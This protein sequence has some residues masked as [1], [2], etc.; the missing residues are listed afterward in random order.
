MSASD[1]SAVNALAARIHP[2]FPE[3]AAVFA[4]RLRLYPDGC[5]VF[6]RGNG[7]EAYVV[8][9]P[10]FQIGPPVL[11]SLLGELP[12]TPAVYYIHD[13]AL[14]PEVRG[15]GAAPEIVAWLAAHALAS[16]LYGMSLIAVN[17]SSG[18]WQRQGFQITHIPQFETKLN[19]YGKDAVYMTRSLEAAVWHPSSREISALYERHAAAF[20]RDRGNRLVERAWFE[21]FRRVMPEGAA[22]LDLGCGSGEPVARYLI[23]A[24]HRVTGI[25]SSLTL[26]DLCRSRFPDQTWIAGDMRR[27]SL[28]RRF[29]GIVAWNSFFHLTPDDQRGMF[30][31]FRDRAE[32]G[33]ALMFTSGPAAGEAIGSYQGEALYHA[34]LA[35]AEYDALLAAHGFS[36]VQHVV[37]DPECGGLTVWLA[38]MR[39]A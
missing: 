15:L 12:A 27:V 24:G 1:L 10:W 34:S 14:A 8:S 9:H 26:I 3:D 18:F 20:D 5:R 19:S 7:I 4:E 29:G 2:S 21:R 31:V 35:A 11:N 23:E 37:E 32:P 17:G 39:P 33:A 30:A 22:V 13:L 16:G 38:Q 36:T 28:P 25:D 6:E